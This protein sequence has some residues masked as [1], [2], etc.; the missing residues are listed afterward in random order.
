MAGRQFTFMAYRDTQMW[1]TITT[2]EDKTVAEVSDRARHIFEQEAWD[3]LEIW[4]DGEM[5][6]CVTERSA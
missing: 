3:R 1:P 6:H 4:V 5:L 2:L